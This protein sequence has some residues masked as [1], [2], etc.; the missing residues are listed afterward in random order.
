MKIC[1]IGKYPPIQGGVSMRSYWTAQ[2]LAARG[3]EVHLVTNAKG[4]EIPYRMYMRPEDWAACE[5]EYDDGFVRV[6]WADPMDGTQMRIPRGYSHV[7]KL[8]SLALEAAEANDVDLFYSFYT[9]P[10]SVAGHM[11]ARL[12]DLPHVIRTAGSDIGRLWQ[13][14]QFA[15]LYNALY[16]SADGIVCSRAVAERMQAAGVARDRLW[17]DLETVGIAPVFAAD[18]P[19]LDVPA[20]I[21]SVRE[22]DDD[23]LKELIFG[24][25]DPERVYFGVYGKLGRSKGTFPLLAALKRLA[26]LGYNVGL[27][28]MAHMPSRR[29]RRHEFHDYLRENGMDS[30]VLQIPYL[31]HW[32]V[33]EFIRRCIAVCCL[34]QDF[35]IVFHR[36]VVAR[37]VLTSGTPL[38]G[39]AEV[40]SK[41]G[42]TD[43]L[44]DGVNCVVI[45]DVN[46]VDNLAA[47]MKALVD[48][49]DAAREIGAHGRQAGIEIDRA[50]T[51]PA[52]LERTLE[53]VV[54]Q[55]RTGAGER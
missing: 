37:E 30:L 34:E 5:S 16:R 38:V 39:S 50:S 12:T 45:R 44:I 53:H 4:I 49:P 21:A 8:S 14:P 23:G 40:V 24:E 43:R 17:L 52:R 19:A 32:R 11:V 25:Y 35:P 31:P 18:G 7:T 15:P 20:L 26:D 51:L 2:L 27:L 33:P 29:G 3:H 55:G 41:I 42:P 10:Y 13:H 22:G 47:R 36:P 28:A 1:M 46:D 54:A 9:E 48:D 6:Y